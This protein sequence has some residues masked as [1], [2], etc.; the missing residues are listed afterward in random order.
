MLGTWYI[1]GKPFAVIQSLNGIRT[2]SISV[3]VDSYVLTKMPCVLYGMIVQENI[4]T[5]YH[6]IT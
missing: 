3:L 6:F 5:L 1:L 2:S 4:C